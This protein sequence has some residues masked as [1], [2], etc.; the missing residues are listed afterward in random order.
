MRLNPGNETDFGDGELAGSLLLAHPA[1][2]DGN[3]RRNVILL[4]G[5]DASQGAV[6]VIL[7]RPMDKTLGQYD[8]GLSGANLT[9]IPLYHGGPVAREQM[10]LLAWKWTEENGL[11]RVYFGIDAE[12]AQSIVSEDPEFEVR[13][14]MGHAGWSEGQLEAELDQGA[15]VV[16]TMVAEARDAE[17]DA[18]WRDILCRANPELRILADEPD[19]PSGN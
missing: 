15:W 18:A 19:D 2:K 3:F 17:G 7:N 9:D 14:F 6:G 12:K 13:G 5:H 8:P 4:T 16:A 10:I 1:L 11:F